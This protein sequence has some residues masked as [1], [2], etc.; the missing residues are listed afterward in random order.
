MMYLSTAI[1]CARRQKIRT[2]SPLE[3]EICLVSLE[4]IDF[5]ANRKQK[6][7]IEPVKGDVPPF[8][9]ILIKLS[10]T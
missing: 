1:E 6:P 8:Y 9:R 2:N 4:N 10:R 7:K 3:T 5:I